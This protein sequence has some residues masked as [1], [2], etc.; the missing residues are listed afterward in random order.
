[1]VEDRLITS[2]IGVDTSAGHAER[3]GAYGKVFDWL[4]V[5]GPAT[6]STMKKAGLEADGKPRERPRLLAEVRQGRFRPRSEGQITSLLC[7]W[8]IVSRR[9]G[10]FNGGVT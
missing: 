5:N 9:R 10:R 1:M 3:V 8:A 6:K 2:L 7:Q 4:L